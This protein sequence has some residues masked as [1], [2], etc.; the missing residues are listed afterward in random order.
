MKGLRIPQTHCALPCILNIVYVCSPSAPTGGGDSDAG[1]GA[2]RC[3]ECSPPCP[4]QQERQGKCIGGRQ[5]RACRGGVTL[6]MHPPSEW[7][8]EHAA[9]THAAE[10][11]AAPDMR[12]R[13]LT[14]DTGGRRQHG[15]QIKYG[16]NWGP[17]PLYTIA[18]CES[19]R[20]LRSPAAGGAR[21]GRTAVRIYTTVCLAECR[22]LPSLLSSGYIYIYTYIHT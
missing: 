14:E 2:K 19:F 20:S 9:L 6:A 18:K 12:E 16:S 1:A 10:L 15:Q 3:S 22:M 17:R 21:T 8:C 13:C 4:R 5:T 7:Q 11:S